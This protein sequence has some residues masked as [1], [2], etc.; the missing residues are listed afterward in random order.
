M[1]RGSI[2]NAIP[3]MLILILVAACATSPPV[4]EMSDAR[5]A[6]TAAEEADADLLAPDVID[7]ARR[8]LVVAERQLQ[9]EAYGLARVNAV[10]AKDR[11][12]EALQVSQAS[13]ELY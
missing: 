2:T 5:Q 8:Y 6:I 9:Q 13:S 4:Q 12:V 1:F 11:A 10:R 7:S 3:V